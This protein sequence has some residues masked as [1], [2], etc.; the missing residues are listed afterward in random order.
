MRRMM[1]LVLLL[2]SPILIRAQQS[3]QTVRSVTEDSD[4]QI[5]APKPSEQSART[6]DRT[7]NLLASRSMASVEDLKIPGRARKEFALSEKSFRAGDVGGWIE[8]MRNA[9]RSAPNWAQAHAALG[10]AYKSTNQYDK[11]IQES[12]KAL[13][14]NPRY[15]DAMENLAAVLCLENRYVEAEPI[16][17]RA[18]ALAPGAASSQF[19]LGGILVKERTYSTEAMTLLEQGKREYPKALI[20][21]AGAEMERGEIEKATESLR[22]YLRL[23]NGKDQPIAK[24]WLEKLETAGQTNK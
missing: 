14:L 4:P 15:R 23:P 17:R 5:V 13:E 9:V 3:K 18:L 1:V 22:E 7:E 2:G 11:S 21:L 16:A 12:E 6:V 8:H 24:D 20:F 19:L 10:A